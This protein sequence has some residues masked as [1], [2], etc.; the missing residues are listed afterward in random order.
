MGSHRLLPPVV[1]SVAAIGLATGLALSG[2]SLTT[3]DV[4]T[5]SDHGECRDRFGLRSGCSADG[6][7]ELRAAHPRCD[8]TYPEGLIDATSAKDVIIIGSL[9]DR[10][11]ETHQAR[12][13][14]A[15]LALKQA[16][17]DG[18]VAGKRFGLVLCT[19]E[20]NSKLDALK[21]T[22]AAVAAARYL[23]EQLGAVA[24]I[25]PSASSDVEAAFKAVQK[26]GALMISPAATS[27]TLTTLDPKQVD[28]DHPGLLWRTAPPDS[29]QGRA[30][31]F[32][33]RRKRIV[34]S[35]AVVLEA[36]PYGEGLAFVFSSVFSADGGKKVTKL[37]F[38]TAGK[39]D[40]H[41]AAAPVDH[42]EV[43]FISAQTSDIIAFLE[44]SA[45]LGT[46]DGKG[47]FL[48]DSANEDVLRQGNDARF[49]Q[50]RGSRPQPLDDK[51]NLVYAAF[52]A[53][54]ATEYGD[55]VRR[56]SFAA[57]SYD[58]A[59]LVAY[60]AAWAQLQAGAINGVN[61]AK[62]LRRV[63]AGDALEIRPSNWKVLQDAFAKGSSVNVEGAS[64]AL[65]Y[66]PSD[67]ETTGAFE[68]WS[69][70]KRA[71]KALYSWP[72]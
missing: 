54:Y 5:C 60:G 61:I 29:V 24:L 32:D 63:S 30:I 39:R 22:D 68:L 51:V 69:I 14:A 57:Q 45:S 9:V 8:R 43:L 38:D 31:A 48:T 49:A 70:D 21:R 47:I 66:E 19:V 42:D 17:E 36:G 65:D 13:R 50:V 12:E 6:L 46:Y 15:R 53:A 62:G 4:T 7:C 34:D 1:A 67:E 71:P 40:E 18:G 44:A 52:I 27:P 72:E 10:S 23:T 16:N 33:M 26:T 28:D 37:V 59:W 3:T 55:D 2:C 56:F 35:V 11:V 58:A 41:V 25:G 20:E 64:G